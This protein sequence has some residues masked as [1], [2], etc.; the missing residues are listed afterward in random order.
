MYRAVK[1]FLELNLCNLGTFTIIHCILSFK[2]VFF[3]IYSTKLLPVVNSI[4]HEDRRSG[5]IEVE[6]FIV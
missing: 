2:I 1:Y 5:K 6:Y 3:S 4:L